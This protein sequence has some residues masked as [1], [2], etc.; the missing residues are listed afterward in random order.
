MPF[1]RWFGKIPV[2]ESLLDSKPKTYPP[3][4]YDLSA[5][6]GATKNIAHD[7]PDLVAKLSKLMDDL[8]ERLD[9]EIRHGYIAKE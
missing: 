9:R 5:D 7:C 6:I 1:E 4:L 3:W 2:E 8:P